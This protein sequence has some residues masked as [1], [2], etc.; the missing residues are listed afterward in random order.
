MVAA[1]VPLPQADHAER[2][3]RLA[4][5]VSLEISD[6]IEEVF[7]TP[8]TFRMGLHTGRLVGGIIGRSTPRFRLVSPRG[9]SAFCVGA[10][11]FVFVACGLAVAP[12]FLFNFLDPALACSS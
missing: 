12:Q 11:F 2:L 4:L 7:G 5:R 6:G 3:A 1:G 8:M 10:S 9:C